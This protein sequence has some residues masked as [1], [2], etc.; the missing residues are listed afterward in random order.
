MLKCLF[1]LSLISG[2]FKLYA[3]ET[4]F[5]DAQN[6]YFHSG[7]FRVI[8]GRSYENTPSIVE[9]ASTILKAMN[10]IWHVQIEEHG[11]LAPR[12][13]A[14][15]S[16]DIYLANTMAYNVETQS[17]ETIVSNF[18]GWATSYPS[19][20]TPYFLIN[21]LLTDNQL[22]VTLAHEFFHTIQYAY[23]DETN[24]SDEKWFKNIWWLEATAMMMED[25]VYDDINDYVSFLT[26]FLMQSYKSVEVY[27]GSH[28]Y[29][30]VIY[31]KFIKEKYGFHIIKE[32][33]KRYESS[34]EKGFFEILDDLLK[35][36]YHSS[37]KAMLIEFG[38]WV[39]EPKRF[40]EEGDLYPLVQRYILSDNTRIEKGGV[41]VL[42]G[43]Y[44]YAVVSSA[45]YAQAF[46]ST[47]QKTVAN[48]EDVIVGNHSSLAVDGSVLSVHQL[49]QD[50]RM[51]YSSFYK[52]D[53]LQASYFWSI[54]ELMLNIN[55]FIEEVVLP[56][57]MY[58]KEGVK[59][60]TRQKIDL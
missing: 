36:L 54:G 52:Y 56:E 49:T 11:F 23:F 37:M 3:T 25:E 20:S 17:Y 7:H 34:A 38:R 35:E 24:I 22:R 16:I 60:V 10:H 19:D 14:F 51:E 42:Q 39:Y 33:L 9:L 48:G 40:F 53:S 55:I 32:S 44:D 50:Y 29:A 30:M 28:E 12:N 18:A 27:N 57:H 15:K 2:V 41:V 21:P 4:R 58:K 26:P 31:A 6:V 1:L 59:C 8:A 13:S 5:V 46:A 43:L 45:L 47:T